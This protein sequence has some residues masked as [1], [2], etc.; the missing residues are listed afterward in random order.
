MVFE[1]KMVKLHKKPKAKSLAMDLDPEAVKGLEII[2]R[3]YGGCSRSEAINH[4]LKRH[5]LSTVPLNLFVE[6]NVV[7]WLKIRAKLAGYDRVEQMV[8]EILSNAMKE[9]GGRP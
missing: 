5:T 2:Q 6:S 7:G 8:E 1:P 4:V 9:H 3:I